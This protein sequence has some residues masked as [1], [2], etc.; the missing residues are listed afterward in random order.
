MNGHRYPNAEEVRRVAEA[1][2][3]PMTVNMIG[4]QAGIPTPRVIFAIKTLRYKGD[5]VPRVLKGKK[6]TYWVR[7]GRWAA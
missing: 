1:L 7:S 5:V 4:R 3:R 2:D 6:G